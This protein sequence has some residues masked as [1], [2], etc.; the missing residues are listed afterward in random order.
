MCHGK[1][2]AHSYQRSLGPCLFASRAVDVFSDL[3]GF[4]KRFTR[5]S[6]L[7]GL[8]YSLVTHW[9]RRQPLPS[10]WKP[11]GQSRADREQFTS[12]G[13]IRGLTVSY[14]GSRRTQQWWDV[15]QTFRN[16]EMSPLWQTLHWSYLRVVM[17]QILPSFSH[18]YARL[19][20]FFKW[21]IHHFI[22][23]T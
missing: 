3:G 14:E 15:T 7:M 19:S 22:Y 8:C 17:P 5:E 20:V 11:W 12:G 6:V 2:C 16:G 9:H 13:Q 21:G 4:W 23:S 18:P 10:C 1:C